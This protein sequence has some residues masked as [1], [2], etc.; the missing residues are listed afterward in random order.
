[1]EIIVLLILV[2]ALAW[3]SLYRVRNHGV[4]HLQFGRDTVGERS[5]LTIKK[6]QSPTLYS[7]V[8]FLG[9]LG[10]LVVTATIGVLIE[11]RVTGSD[12]FLKSLPNRT[13]AIVLGI[14]L[15]T[16]VPLGL[17]ELDFA[18]FGRSDKR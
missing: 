18:I 10:A 13:N 12:S 2:E 16:Q 15:I 7:V 6:T 1:M 11:S 4:I 17:S 14:V 3:W 5:Y 8:F 9:S